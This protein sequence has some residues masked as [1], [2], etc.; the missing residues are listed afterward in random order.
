LIDLG[1]LGGLAVLHGIRGFSEET[2]HSYRAMLLIH[3]HVRGRAY[4][5]TRG[6]RE[7]LTREF[8]HSRDLYVRRAGRLADSERDVLP[9][10]LGLSPQGLSVTELTEHGRQAA[11]E[12]GYRNPTS[13]HAISFSFYEAATRNPLELEAE[14]VPALVQLALFD[15]EPSAGAPS[16]ELI[17]TVTERLLEAIH[18]HLADPQEQFDR[19][20]SGPNN[21]LVK[22]LA[23]RQGRPGGRLPR[24]EV[25]QALLA[26]GW[27]AYE[28][29]GQCIH[30]LMRTIKQSI[31]EP[32]S[33]DEQRLFEHMFE[34][35]L[36]YGGFPAALLAERM[37][38]LGR[39]V[40]AIWREPENPAHVRVLHR[41][42]QYYLEMVRPR[43][44][45][46]R[47]S[48]RR[49]S[50]GASGSSRGTGD[51]SRAETESTGDAEER[52]A[53]N[54]HAALEPHGGGPVRLIEN[55]H[56]SVSS[57]VDPF[58]IVG[59]HLRELRQVECPAGCLYWEY[60]RKG[61]AKQSVAIQMRC[62]CGKVER[63][64]RMSMNEFAKQ[65]QEALG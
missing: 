61:N 5:G 21:S 12:A 28:Y 58:K 30:A 38:F 36:Y 11:Q 44:Q 33:D 6:M 22:Q 32:L 14:E 25:R 29:V 53:N 31:V 56:S 64:I 43:R 46:D 2:D 57:D 48:K 3:Q 52:T 65:A 34:S 8:Q 16:P 59:D 42:L 39:A 27:R 37:R 41:L 13:R 20:F 4:R 63:T 18:R 51:A 47:Q 9:E 7:H 50:A 15:L 60:R 1:A 40:L 35:Q 24:D 23:Q 45:A 17:D 19:W 26:L 10:D 49:S 62:E 55:L 54:G